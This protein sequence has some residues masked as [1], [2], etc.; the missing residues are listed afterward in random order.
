MMIRENLTDLTV[1]GFFL[2]ESRKFRRRWFLRLSDAFR[3]SETLVSGLLLLLVAA[4][5]KLQKPAWNLTV[6]TQ[7][8]KKR[9]GRGADP[10]SL[11]ARKAF[12]SAE[13]ARLS[14]G[15]LPD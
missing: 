11:L 3:D 14:V 4:H 2:S 7:S 5:W 6:C 13:P 1:K 8:S 10:L 15:L 12:A 9:R